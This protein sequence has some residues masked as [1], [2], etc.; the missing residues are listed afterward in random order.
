MLKLD[1]DNCYLFMPWLPVLEGV[2]TLVCHVDWMACPVV[3]IF[4][5]RLQY[6][7]LEVV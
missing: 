4:F 7:I 5:V 2:V 1:S 3:G 6:W